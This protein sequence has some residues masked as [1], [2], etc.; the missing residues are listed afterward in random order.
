MVG[1]E[2]Q[3]SK[4]LTS[5]ILGRLRRL[6]DHLRLGDYDEDDMNEDPPAPEAHHNG[7]PLQPRDE[8]LKPLWP[9]LRALEQTCSARANPII[10]E[11]GRIKGLWMR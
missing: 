3:P 8:T 2:G 11:E 1:T 9:S 5:N 7:L 6:E 10:W 4:A